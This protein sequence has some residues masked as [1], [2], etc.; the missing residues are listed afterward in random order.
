MEFKNQITVA[1]DSKT[2]W[3]SSMKLELKQQANLQQH[4]QNNNIKQ[5]CSRSKENEIN[6]NNSIEMKL[7]WIAMT[8][9]INSIHD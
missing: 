2:N 4:I 8:L 5:K 7:K 3:N 1:H 9:E 6:K